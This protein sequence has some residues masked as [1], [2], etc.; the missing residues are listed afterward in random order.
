MCLAQGA[1]HSD[2]G[3]ARTRGPSVLS[4]TLYTEPLSSLNPGLIRKTFT[5]EGWIS[6]NLVRIANR[7]DPDQT[8]LGLHCLSRPLG[9]LAG[10]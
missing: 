10:I 5:H 1:Q 4:Q 6:Q 2:A 3:E 8:D 9:L 7:E